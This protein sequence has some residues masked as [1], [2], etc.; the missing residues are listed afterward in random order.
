MKHS[1]L[2]KTIFENGKLIFRSVSNEKKKVVLLELRHE[3][4]VK[5]H[6]KMWNVVFMP[7]VKLTAPK[8]FVFAMRVGRIIQ[9]ILRL[10]AKI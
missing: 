1:F 7:T 9:A 8:R 6:A 10:D 2:I 3:L 5:H 4:P